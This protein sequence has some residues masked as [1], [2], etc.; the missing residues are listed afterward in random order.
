MESCLY[1]GWVRHRRFDPVDHALAM[2]LF[3]VYLDLDELPS[4]FAGRWLWSAERPALARFRRQDHLGDPRV[5]LQLAVR[6]LV[7]ERSGRR[8]AG[9]IRLLTHLRYFGYAFNPVS[10][11][12]CFGEQGDRLDAIVAEVTNTPWKERHCYVFSADEA[13][14]SGKVYRFGHSKD[15]HVSPF[16]GMDSSYRWSIATPGRRL[17]VGIDSYVGEEKRIFRA[18][19]SMRRQEITS[20]SLARALVRYPMMTAQVIARIYWEAQRLR[21]KRVPVHPHPRDLEGRLEVAV[22]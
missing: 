16:M 9:P 15:F 13:E 17:G 4:V 1:E 11:F 10:L 19:L 20:R 21:R 22:P 5:P 14:G 12:Y 3:M 7:E 18:S 8:P 6:D 2:R